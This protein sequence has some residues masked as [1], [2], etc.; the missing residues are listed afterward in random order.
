LIWSPLCTFSSTPNLVA[1]NAA[2]A[3]L[4]ATNSFY[5][6]GRVVGDSGAMTMIE[7]GS[8]GGTEQFRWSVTG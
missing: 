4:L 6:S 1:D 8:I 2:A 7:H 5:T 3:T